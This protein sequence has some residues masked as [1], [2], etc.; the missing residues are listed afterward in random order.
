MLFPNLSCIYNIISS[1][2]SDKYT[3]NQTPHITG[4]H[5]CGS[6]IEGLVESIFLS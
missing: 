6:S 2:N 4:A 1:S 5:V 3:S